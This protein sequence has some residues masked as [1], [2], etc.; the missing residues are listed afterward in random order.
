MR[1][2]TE[3]SV[4]PLTSWAEGPVFVPVDI[5]VDRVDGTGTAVVVSM[6]EVTLAPG[7]SVLL[8]VGG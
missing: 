7:V 4:E 5:S 6:E 1:V 8:S 3:A 2:G